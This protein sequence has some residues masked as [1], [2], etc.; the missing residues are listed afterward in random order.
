MWPETFG[1]TLVQTRPT[2]W[3][4]N[5][6]RCDNNNKKFLYMVKWWQWQY[7]LPLPHR[8]I[9]RIRQIAPVCISSDTLLPIGLPQTTPWSVHPF[10]Q[11]LQSWHT[12]YGCTDRYARLLRLWLSATSMLRI[13]MWRHSNGNKGR[14]MNCV[15]WCFQPLASVM[16][17]AICNEEWSLRPRDR[18]YS[19]RRMT[20][21]AVRLTSCT[22]MCR[23]TCKR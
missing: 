7:T 16:S 23:P 9:H 22:C 1:T 11:S 2:H 3:Q 14:P 12:T 19:S 21:I 15:R 20:V 18:D 8:S 17:S 5:I 4:Y 10:S 6:T 13:A